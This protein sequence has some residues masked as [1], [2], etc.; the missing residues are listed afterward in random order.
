[1]TR[2]L[3]MSVT[4]V[5]TFAFTDASAQIQGPPPNAPVTR[6]GREPIPEPTK[7]PA[8]LPEGIALEINGPPAKNMTPPSPDPKDFAGTYFHREDL[9]ARIRRTMYG[10]LTPYSLE[11]QKTLSDRILKDNAGT[12]EVN[13]S[14]RC[15]PAGPI[16]QMDLNFPFRI[17]QRPR[18]IYFVFEEYHGLMTVRMNARHM[19]DGPRSYMGDSV[20]HWE[21]DTLVVETT[22]FKSDMWLDVLGSP[23]SK[24]GTL[25]QRYRKIE[26]GNALEVVTTVHDPINYDH[27]WS[28][29]RS[30]VW[31]PD[32]AV[33]GEYNC[34]FE[35]GGPDGPDHH[36]AK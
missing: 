8:E 2:K 32:K 36:G 4:A 21:H 5:L 30:E 15:I 7:T 11:G 26:S 23:L 9:V 18:V 27:D 28:F 12:P 19:T 25:T 33:L 20:G 13:A 31:R 17:I 24:D 34:E 29:A 6:P 16:W 3:V 14:S 10:N 35:T 1:M 22:R